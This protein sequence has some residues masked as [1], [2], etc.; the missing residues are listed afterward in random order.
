MV[1]KAEEEDGGLL[2]GLGG[3]CIVPQPGELM[4]LL[5]PN[6]DPGDMVSRAPP[7]HSALNGALK[8]GLK[9]SLDGLA[10]N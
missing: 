2:A 7:Y 1:G 10:L 6:P 9:R 8:P 3:H 4:E 5:H